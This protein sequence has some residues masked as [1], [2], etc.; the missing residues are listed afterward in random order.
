MEYKQGEEYAIR[1]LESNSYKVVDRRN[2]RRYWKKDIDLTV[3]RDGKRQD[4]EVKWDSII[5]NNGNFFI[6]LV[7]DVEKNKPGWF[8][9]TEAD[10]IF[11]GDS[12]NKLF[13]V[14][15]TDDMRKYLDSTDYEIRT[16]KENRYDGSEKISKG[17]IIP[18]EDYR[19]EYQI[20]V[21]DIEE[22]L[23]EKTALAF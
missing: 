11:Y 12:K 20:Q 17:A 6:E 5:S 21:I 15:R 14:F 10:F 19:K 3:E 4:I 1:C 2:D 13:Y 22:R 9:Y 8:N 23:G 16:S 18:I 7:T